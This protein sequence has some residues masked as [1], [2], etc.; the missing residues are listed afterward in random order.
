MP[1]DPCD[2]CA[3]GA[4][5]SIVGFT[6]EGVSHIHHAPA[7]RVLFLSVST[8][9]ASAVYLMAPPRIIDE[10][11]VSRHGHSILCRFHLGHDVH[12]DEASADICRSDPS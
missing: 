5:E 3:K 10:V 7:G 1:Q 11:T 9:L 4:H 6:H 2:V 8:D 12:L